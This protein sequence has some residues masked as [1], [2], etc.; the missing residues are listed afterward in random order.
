MPNDTLYP[1]DYIFGPE[2]N[3]CFTKKLVK[4]SQSRQL[5]SYYGITDQTF[6]KKVILKK[7]VNIAVCSADLQY[8]APTQK[9]RT[10]FCNVKNT[11]L[12][13]TVLLIGYTA[14]EWIIKN[15]W[16]TDWGVGGFGYISRNQN[17]NCCIG[18]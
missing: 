4:I 3:M 10:L 6:I 2:D 12:D 11:V 5:V 7:P 14:T 8:Y 13:H 9:V 1:Y 18:Q 16:G 15:Q 17:N